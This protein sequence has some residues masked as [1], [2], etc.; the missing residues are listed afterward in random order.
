MTTIS[1]NFQSIFGQAMLYLV[2]QDHSFC[3][4]VSTNRYFA[5]NPFDVFGAMYHGVKRTAHLFRSI[6]AA[7]RGA[8]VPFPEINNSIRSPPSVEYFPE[9]AVA[10]ARQWARLRIMN[11]GGAGQLG[12]SRQLPS[13]SACC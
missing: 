1:M 13:S 8:R 10:R 4:P 3:F 7:F 9:N 5:N 2:D 11:D 6:F 12:E